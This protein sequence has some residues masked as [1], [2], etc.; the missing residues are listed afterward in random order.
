[1]TPFTKEEQFVMDKLVDALKSFRKL[2]VTHPTAL[3][4]FVQGIHLCKSQ[5]EHRILQRDYPDTFPTHKD[6]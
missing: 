4:E 5:L 2:E 1:M 6:E 3:P